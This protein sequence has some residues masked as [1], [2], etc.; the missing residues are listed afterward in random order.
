MSFLQFTVILTPPDVFGMTTRGLEYGDVECWISSAAR[1]WLRVA[2][3]SLAEIGLMRWGLETIGA[4]PLG[5]E[6]SKGI[7]EQEPKSVF[8]VE[9]TQGNSKSTSPGCSSG[10]YVSPVDDAIC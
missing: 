6:I 4:L 7:K 10:R 2:S 1:Y 3:T 5:T 8:E 9:N